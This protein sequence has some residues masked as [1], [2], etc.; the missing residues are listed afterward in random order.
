MFETIENAEQAPV[1]VFG[2]QMARV[3]GLN[4][5]D[6]ESAKENNPPTSEFE[7]GPETYMFGDWPHLG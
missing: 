1:R 2:R 4:A 6:V 7:T 3:R 5:V